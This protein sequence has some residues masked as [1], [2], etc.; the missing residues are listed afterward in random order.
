M[1]S[2]IIALG[3]GAFT[4]IAFVGLLASVDAVM[5]LQVIFTGEPVTNIVTALIPY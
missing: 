2:K 4:H 1:F 5:A 3:K